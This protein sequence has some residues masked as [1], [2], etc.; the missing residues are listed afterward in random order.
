MDDFDPNLPS[1]KPVVIRRFRDMPAALLGKSILDSAGIESFLS[2]QN[3]IRMDWL[4]S[5]AL[6]QLRLWVRQEDAQAATELL[7]QQVVDDFP[8]DGVGEFKQIHCP[9]CNSLDVNYVETSGKTLLLGS[10]DIS[11]PTHWTCNSCNH[12]WSEPAAPAPS[13]S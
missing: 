6:G 12:Q 5:N 8:V 3:T 1:Q 9:A 4:W 13:D 7:D 11:E 2:D 10:P